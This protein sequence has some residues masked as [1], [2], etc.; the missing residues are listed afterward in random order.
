MEVKIMARIRTVKPEFWAS[1]QIAN[2]SRDTRLLFIGMWTFC[3]DSGIHPA[4][5]KRLK[6]QV[7]PA[8]H[9][10][11]EQMKAWI[12]ELLEQKLIEEYTVNGQVFWQ[13]TGWRHQLIK[14]P[15]YK[16]PTRTPP[17]PHQTIASDVVVQEQLETSPAPVHPV[18]RD[19]D[20]NINRKNKRQVAD[21]TRPETLEIFTYWQTAMNHPKAKLDQKR[22]RVIERALKDYSATDLK[23]A[24][25]G[26]ASSEF[27]MGVNPQKQKYDDIS[28]ILR[29]AQHIES[30]INANAETDSVFEGVI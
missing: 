6:M 13:V 9:I 14:K 17:S 10:P 25:D 4:S 11:D 19:R 21:T 1:E 3:D 27:H 8:D 5:S 2:C 28:L 7:F 23:R 26:C 20:R 18:N 16:Y 22:Q 12:A 15:C 29:D 30:F 24:I